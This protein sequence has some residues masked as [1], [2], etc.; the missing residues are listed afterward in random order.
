MNWVKEGDQ[1]PKFYHA[2]IK[3][4]KKWLL[5]QITKEKDIVTRNLLEIGDLAQQ[6]FST[7]FTHLLTI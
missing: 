7:L 1:N 6:Y 5:I 3:E 2:V 4:K